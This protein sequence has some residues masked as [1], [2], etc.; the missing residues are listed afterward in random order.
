MQ[1][2]VKSFFVVEGLDGAGTTTQTNKLH[3]Y[4]TRNGVNS[5]PTREPTGRP[6]GKFIRKVLSRSVIPAEGGSPWVPGERELALLFA[7]DRLE[8]TREIAARRDGGALVLC[9]RYIFSS[10]AYQTLDPSISAEWVR[11]I[12]RGCAVPDVT[13]LLLVSAEECLRRI[14]S[15]NEKATVYEKLELLERIN[16]NYDRLAAYYEDSFGPLVKIDGSKSEEE[17]HA[18][19]VETLHRRFNV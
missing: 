17:V 4:F 10:M 3:E 9:D 15:R 18:R 13:F 2:P 16:Q 12:N 8:H 7:A 6:V 11:E 1:K 19:I 14:S 5:F